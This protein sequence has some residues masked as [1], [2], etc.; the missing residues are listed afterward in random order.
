MSDIVLKTEELTKK[1]LGAY[2]VDHVAMEVNRG[3]IYGFI[4]VNGA[5]K[6]TFMRMACGL[7]KPTK[8]SMEL[9]GASQGK[10]LRMA[11]KKMGALIEHP[12]YY[13]T[14]TAMENL[15]VQRR[16]LDMD[17]GKDRKKAMQELLEL[18]GLENTG[19]K[20]AGAFS[21]GMKQRLGLAIALIGNPELLILDE[22]TIGLDPVGVVELRELLVKLNREKNITIFF[23]S[24]NLSEMERL[25]TRYGFLHKGKLVKEITAEK[26]EEECKARELDLEKYFM[27]LVVRFKVEEKKS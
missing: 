23:S 1:Y 4:G 27:D 24:H 12:A 8:G 9:F 13:P 5:G 21:L 10:D 16:Y 14:M 25:A 3:D 6:T 20:R 11:R 7:V 2:A 17:L 22:P 19:K 15:E 18:V 26:L